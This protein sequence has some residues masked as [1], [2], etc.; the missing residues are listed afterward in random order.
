VKDCA[1]TERLRGGIFAATCHAKKINPIMIFINSF[2]RQYP[3]S[4][5]IV[6]Q[7][8]LPGDATAGAGLCFFSIYRGKTHR[9]ISAFAPSF[10]SG[11]RSLPGKYQDS[12]SQGGIGQRIDGG[13]KAQSQ[14]KEKPGHALSTYPASQRGHLRTLTSNDKQILREG[15]VSHN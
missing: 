10:P 8:P 15:Q 7:F 2:C 12:V 14:G 11:R 5:S 6:N 13:D 1:Y 4:V 9:V 3:W